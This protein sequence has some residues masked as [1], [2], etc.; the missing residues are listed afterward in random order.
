MAL[1]FIDDVALVARA[2]SYQEANDK[3]KNMMKR[4]GGALDWN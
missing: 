4:L 3:L 2:R 1:G